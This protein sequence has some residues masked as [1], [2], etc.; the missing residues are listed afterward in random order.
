MKQETISY[1]YFTR[2]KLS[3]TVFQINVNHLIY[4]F[5]KEN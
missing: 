2:N 1:R 3:K 5:L 4:T